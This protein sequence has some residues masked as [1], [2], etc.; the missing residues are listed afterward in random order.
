MSKISREIMDVIKFMVD[1][2]HVISSEKNDYTLLSLSKKG[3]KGSY[4]IL[5]SNK[6][7]YNYKNYF[8]NDNNIISLEN[9][10]KEFYKYNR[11]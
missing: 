9:D 11:R 1:E 6:I 8:I 10:I 3:Y 2:L 7:W 5:E 4:I